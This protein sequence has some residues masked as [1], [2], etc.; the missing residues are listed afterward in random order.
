MKVQQLLEEKEID[1]RGDMW[2]AALGYRRSRRRDGLYRHCL[3][4]LGFQLADHLSAWVQNGRIVA[5]VAHLYGFNA[6][7]RKEILDRCACAGLTT[8]IVPPP[9]GWY[10]YGTTMVVYRRRP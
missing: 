4:A 8:E 2:A 1:R 7:M 9:A 6:E 5:C 10:G 3:G